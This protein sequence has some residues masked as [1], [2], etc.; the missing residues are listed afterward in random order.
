MTGALTAKEVHH[1]R[2]RRRAV[3]A[4]VV[5]NGF[6][7][8]DF[9]IYGFLAGVIA[10]LFFPVSDPGLALLLASG[11]FAISFVVRPLGGL[12]FAMHADRMGRRPAL[13]LM[14]ALM[15]G[16][17]LA[18][19]L[20]PTYASIGL[21]APLLLLLARLVQGLSVGAEF[22]TATAML[23]EW[24]PPGRRLRQGSLQMCTQ[25]FAMALAA[26]TVAALSS[27]LPTGAMRE[28]GWR[29]PFLL[30]ALIGPV[31]FYLRRSVEESPAFRPPP[32]EGRTG[33]QPLAELLATHRDRLLAGFG[34][35]VVGTTSQYVWFV[36]LPVFVTNQLGLDVAAAM[37]GSSLCGAALVVLTFVAGTLADRWGGWRIFALGTAMFGLLAWPL[38]ADVIAHP[39][40]GRLLAAQALCTVAIS[41]IWGPTPGLLAGLYP[42]RMRSTGISLC[43]NLGVLLFG[44]LAPFTLTWAIRMSH[45]RM[46]PAYY[47]TACATIA[48]A[49]TARQWMPARQDREART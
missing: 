10:P 15:A 48:L 23:T 5:G 14:L 8:Y 18:I 46:M 21:T 26:A 28:W 9:L 32:P 13:A 47:I 37:L 45:D 17:T 2:A 29:L 24:A 49:M 42:M 34:V 16:S 22:A 40:L 33:A 7:W 27:L 38:L 12:F 39:G 35:V 3:L 44:G 19:G 31:G 41:L 1:A 43:Y 30:G 20:I 6:E 25:A 36:Y 11:T 4:S